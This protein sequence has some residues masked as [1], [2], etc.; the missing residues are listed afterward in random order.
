MVDYQLGGKA[1]LVT[2]GGSGIGLTCCHVLARSGAHVR[3]ADL[4]L[5][6]A[7]LV[8]DRIRAEGGSAQAVEV[9]VTDQT[10]VDLM[11]ASI[12]RDCGRLDAAVNNAGIGAAWA[13]IA[14]VALETWRRVMAVN[15]DGVFLCLRAETN[16]M[17]NSGGGSIVNMASVMAT[18][19]HPGS[20]P[21]VAS[22]H[23]VLGLTRTAA[24]DHAQDGIRVNAVA[25]GFIRTPLL[26][27][28]HDPGALAALA[29]RHAL[30]RLGE[31]EEVAEMV[32]WLVSD[33]SSFTT[34]AIFHVDGAYAVR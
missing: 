1:V 23:G 20:A 7:E 33:A 27:E 29:A 31:P 17:R 12:V 16:A 6:A 3:V 13:P 8:A 25:P 32:A 19:A 24:L 18:V 10:S 30:G 28:R 26:D 21:Y 4:R 34:G 11:V 22:K 14:E 2:G 9:D 5:D 15:L